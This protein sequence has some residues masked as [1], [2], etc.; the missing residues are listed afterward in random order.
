AE[1]VAEAPAGGPAMAAEEAA[2]EEEK[3]RLAALGT[4]AQEVRKAVGEFVL[5]DPKYASGIIRKWMKERAR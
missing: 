4:Q 5:S 3:K 1:V 2:I